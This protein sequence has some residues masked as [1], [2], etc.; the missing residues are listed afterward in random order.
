MSTLLN[1][2]KK[3]VN[4]NFSSVFLMLQVE[5]L[6]CRGCGS[7]N[8]DYIDYYHDQYGNLY[9]CIDEVIV[10]PDSTSWGEDDWEDEYMH[11][12]QGFDEY[13]DYSGGGGGGGDNGQDSSQVSVNRGRDFIE[14]VGE[15]EVNVVMTSEVA[16][17]LSLTTTITSLVPTVADI[18]KQDIGILGAIGKWTGG[19]NMA[20]SAYSVAIGFTDGEVSWK[21][22]VNAGSLAFSIGSIFVPALGLVSIGLAV[23]ATAAPGDQ[24]TGQNIYS[25]GGQY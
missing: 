5:E 16:D 8:Y 11:M 15:G 12:G 19:L 6:E 3:S 4:S 21:D 20:Y 2:K 7:Y 18:V 17:F 9:G 22:I 13:P 1:E 25:S 10:T 14:R 24:G 23:A